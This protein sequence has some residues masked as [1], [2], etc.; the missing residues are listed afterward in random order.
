[1]SIFSKKKEAPVFVSA[2]VAAAGTASRMNG[3]DKQMAELGGIPVVARSIG[4]LCACPRVAEVVVVCREEQIADYYDLVRYYGFGKVA[5]VVSGGEHRQDSV[6]AGIRACRSEAGYY[7]VHDGARPLVLPDEIERCIDA[8]IAA[9]AAAVGVPVKDTI[10][11]C[12]E[13]GVIISTPSR[14][15]LWAVQT[16]QIFE[17]ELYRRAMEAALRGGKRYTDDCQLVEAI[18]HKVVISPGSYENIKIT[19]QA[20]IA[21]AGAILAFRDSISE[22][23]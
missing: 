5:S 12:G 17:A 15:T 1:M 10:K 21:V 3:E 20:D 8:A 14:D 4:A 18:G 6:F 2:V 13:N 23:L 7:A 11:V 9:K 16:P 19:T 22:G